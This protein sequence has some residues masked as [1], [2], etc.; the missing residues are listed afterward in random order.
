MLIDHWG[1]H[2]PI[3][4]TAQETNKYI[5]SQVF[6]KVLENRLNEHLEAVDV[7]DITKTLLPDTID[8]FEKMAARYD[9]WKD[10][11][12]IQEAPFWSG[13]E[14][15]KKELAL[16]SIKNVWRTRDLEKAIECLAKVS[17][18]D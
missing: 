2:H 7:S 12:C 14:D 5:G 10:L 8:R 3:I 17:E 1:L 4:K 18:W 13:T 9:G 11:K 16:L 6:A 15:V